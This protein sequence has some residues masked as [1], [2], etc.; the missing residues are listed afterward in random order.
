ML[1]VVRLI[2][3]HSYDKND[4]PT[5]AWTMLSHIADKS[6][7]RPIQKFVISLSVLVTERPNRPTAYQSSSDIIIL[8]S[9]KWTM[10]NMN[11]VIQQIDI[12]LY[13]LT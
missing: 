1:K 2:Q 11:L 10:T 5:K 3:I 6:Q 12:K 13:C 7:I 9:A 4:D 8:T